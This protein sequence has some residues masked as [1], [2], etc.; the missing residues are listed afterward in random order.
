SLNIFWQDFLKKLNGGEIESSGLKVMPPPF[1]KR[2]GPKMTVLDI[3]SLLRQELPKKLLPAS[4]RGPRTWAGDAPAIDTKH[5]TQVKVTKLQGAVWAKAC[6]Q[7]K[8]HGVTPHAVLMVSLLKAWAEVYRDE[9]ALETVTPINCRH[10]CEPP[11][12]A[13]E[14]GNFISTYNPTWRRKEIQKT[15]FWTLARRYQVLL[16]A[17]KHEAAK[18]VFH[19]DFL[20][21]FPEAY[22]QFWQDKR[23]CRM[24]RSG[25]LE[26]SDLGKI[27]LPTHDKSWT[28]RET[29]FCQS[30]H[31]LLTA[32]GVNTITAAGAMHVAFCWQRGAL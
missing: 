8:K 29:Y 1:E 19:L 26:F 16:R 7:A 2:N 30:A 20:T 18:R 27:S 11:V 5:D 13:N 25:G 28:V 31:T 15:E 22:F 14:M 17:D 3:A 23:K 12:P 6:I 4:W 21:P 9:R 10:M 24:G 32:M